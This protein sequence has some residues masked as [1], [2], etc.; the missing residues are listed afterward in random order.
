MFM[1]LADM[2]YD[3]LDGKSVITYIVNCLYS[4]LTSNVC[5]PITLSPDV[6]ETFTNQVNDCQVLHALF[7]FM[8]IQKKMFKAQTD[9]NIQV[10]TFT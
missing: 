4:L 8:H 9:T 10:S 2:E 7:Y 1:C 5:S 6:S 3:R